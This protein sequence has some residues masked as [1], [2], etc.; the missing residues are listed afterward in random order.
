[1]AVAE[2]A[3]AVTAPR[4]MT[5]GCVTTCEAPPEN[6]NPLGVITALRAAATAETVIIF[7]NIAIVLQTDM[8]ATFR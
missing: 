7:R 1:M 2:Y 8:G 5:T 3:I 6:A 4:L